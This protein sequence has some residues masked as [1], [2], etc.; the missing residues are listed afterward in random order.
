M[1][2]RPTQYTADMRPEARAAAEEERRT[3]RRESLRHL[4][5]RAGRGVLGAS[6]AEL[7]R[8][9]VDAELRLSD[10][11]RAGRATWKA[12]AEEIERDRDRADA[13][14]AETKRLMER[15]TTTLRERAERAEVFL[16]TVADVIADHEGDEWADHSATTA[17]RVAITRAA[18]PSGPAATA[19]QRLT[20]EQAAA[21]RAANL[22]PGTRVTRAVVDEAL[23]PGC[24][25]T[26]GQRCP[27]CR[28]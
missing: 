26:Y 13:V 16:N 22:P 27:N 4:L 20:E 11:L 21:V 12:K 15:R 6:E 2:D 28:D 14:T 18:V 1:N 7:L 5:D 25:C 3:A 24:G 8:T 17:I 9:Q 23:A 10:Q 19:G